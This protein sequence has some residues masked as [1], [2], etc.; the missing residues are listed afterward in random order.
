MHSSRRRGHQQERARQRASPQDAPRVDTTARGWRYPYRHPP[1]KRLEPASRPRFLSLP[2]AVHLRTTV[3]ASACRCGLAVLHLGL[4]GVPHLPHC[5]A[6]EAV[7]LHSTSPP[8]F[9]SG[10][11]LSLSWHPADQ[12]RFHAARGRRR[13]PFLGDDITELIV[14]EILRRLRRFPASARPPLICRLTSP[15]VQIRGERGGSGT[16]LAS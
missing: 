5:A 7:R 14:T 4:L 12:T 6:L 11:A 10:S 3:R 2:D 9:P 16:L 1:P 8:Y 15:S 13:P